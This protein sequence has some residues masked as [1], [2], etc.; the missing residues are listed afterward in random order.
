[1][2]SFSSLAP[3]R[4]RGALPDKKTFQKARKNKKNKFCRVAVVEIENH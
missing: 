3:S 1:L 2:G 4:L